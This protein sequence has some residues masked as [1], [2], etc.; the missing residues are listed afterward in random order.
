MDIR[1]LRFDIEPYFFFFEK[2]SL[3]NRTQVDS[4][5][6]NAKVSE[7]FH[8]LRFISLI[9]LGDIPLPKERYQKIRRLGLWD[10]ARSYLEI[11]RYPAEIRYHSKNADN[12]KSLLRSLGPSLPH[13]V[14]PMFK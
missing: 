4:V 9:L 5:L 1:K 13:F 11:K 7:L 3:C 10:R 12:M 14:S 2:I 8:L 6:S